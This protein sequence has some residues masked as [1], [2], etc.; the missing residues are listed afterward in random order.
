MSEPQDD[1]APAEPP[2][3]TLYRKVAKGRRRLTP[4]RMFM[5][6]VAVVMGWWL[7]RPVRH[8]EQ[9][10]VRLGASRFD[11]PVTVGG[12]ADLRQL[13]KRV[14]WLR[15]RLAELEADRERALRHVSHELKTPLTALKEGVSLL[16]EEVPGPLGEGQR[17]VVDIL[18]HTVRVLQEQIESQT[19]NIFTGFPFPNYAPA[20]RDGQAAA[21]SAQRLDRAPAH[22]A[23]VRR[24]APGVLVAP[25]T[26]PAHLDLTVPVARL[27]E[28][29]D[30]LDG[31]EGGTS[32]PAEARELASG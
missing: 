29:V 2:H 28:T 26:G 15:Q 5:Y 11:E 16:R 14:D 22:R 10:I 6:R 8:L 7:V 17:E 24:C 30:L 21:P 18:Q 19:R 25:L 23:L 1:E 3:R 4:A 31:S 9:A 27:R 12:P 20:A 13:G 32:D